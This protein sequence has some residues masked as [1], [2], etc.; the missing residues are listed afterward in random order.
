[1]DHIDGFAW[2]DY[3]HKNQYHT[4]WSVVLIIWANLTEPGFNIFTKLSVVPLICELVTSDLP[5]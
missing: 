4:K 2:Q 5:P 3:L 1:M